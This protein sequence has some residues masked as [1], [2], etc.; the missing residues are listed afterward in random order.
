MAHVLVIEVR[1]DVKVVVV[2]VMTAIGILAVVVVVAL[3]S[4]KVVR[5]FLAVGEVLML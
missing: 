2:F 1:Y 5:V 4:I 3:F